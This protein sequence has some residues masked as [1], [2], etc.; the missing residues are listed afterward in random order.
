MKK[1]CKAQLPHLHTARSMQGMTD[2]LRL[3]NN[4][5]ITPQLW[6]VSEDG[7]HGDPKLS[8][9]PSAACSSEEPLLDIV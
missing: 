7:V 8:R 6:H 4:V 3:V 9:L 2:R 5:M 1:M